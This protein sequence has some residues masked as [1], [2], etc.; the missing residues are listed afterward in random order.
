LIV[1]NVTWTIAPRS[2]IVLLGNHG[3]ASILLGMI[4]G[5]SLPTQG[6]IR[7]QATI[8]VPGGFLRHA[9]TGNVRQLIE[10]LSEVYNADPRDIGEFIENGLRSRRVLDVPVPRLPNLLRRQMNLALSYALPCDFYMFD[11]AVESGTDPAFRTFCQQAFAARRKTA[12]TI[13]ATR[14]TSMAST[15]DANSVG[16]VLYQRKIT[17]Y[18]RLTDAIAVFDSLPP[19]EAIPKE[20]LV[21]PDSQEEEEDFL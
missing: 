1:D 14:T 6:W 4:A 8:S 3:T 15:F 13:V 2:Q 9:K 17:L 19:E 10:V 20:A 18:E 21:D 12:G 11:G 7:R 5:L 16:A